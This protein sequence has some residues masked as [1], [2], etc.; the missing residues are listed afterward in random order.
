M[1]AHAVL[2]SQ[3]LNPACHRAD[4]LSELRASHPA[5]TDNLT[6]TRS[7]T[8]NTLNTARDTAKSL[9]WDE[10]RNAEVDLSSAEVGPKA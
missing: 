10:F 5:T 6:L 2:C 1:K 8:E 4:T 9:V 3:P 7:C